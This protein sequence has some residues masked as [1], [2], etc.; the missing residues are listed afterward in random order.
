MVGFWFILANAETLAEAVERMEFSA[1]IAGRMPARS[2]A[3]I[4]CKHLITVRYF[5]RG[6]KLLILYFT[7]RIS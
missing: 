1:V 7:F 6:F 3:E 5:M 4:C 2:A